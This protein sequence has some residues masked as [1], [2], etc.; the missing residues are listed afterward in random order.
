MLAADSTACLSPTQETNI[1]GIDMKTA[2]I[3]QAVAT[4]IDHLRVLGLRCGVST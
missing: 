2:P 4:A 3:R 1:T